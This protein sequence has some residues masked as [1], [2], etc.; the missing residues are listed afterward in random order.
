MA[1]EIVNKIAKA[2]ILQ[3]DLGDFVTRE[4]IIEFDLKDGLWQEMVIKEDLFR[5]FVKNTNWSDFE[6]KIQIYYLSHFGQIF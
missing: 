3:I 1:E 4:Q 6:S 2:N 5:D